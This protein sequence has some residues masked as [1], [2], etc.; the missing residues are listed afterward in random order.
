MPE[1]L[2][3]AEESA[4][5]AAIVDYN[6]HDQNGLAI[7]WRLR[8]LQP[9]CARILCTGRD[10]LPTFLDAVNQ[11][12]ISKIVR[13]PFRVPELLGH[14]EE[15]L[16]FRRQRGRAQSGDEAKQSLAER[17]ALVEVMNGGM[18]D[19]AIQPIVHTSDTQVARYYEG[20]IRPK[21]TLLDNPIALL[22]AA[23]NQGRI[24]EISA[25]ALRRVLAVLPSIP[26]EVGLFVNL[27]PEQLGDPASLAEILAT[28]QDDA[29]RIVLEITERS[30]LHDIERWD[31]SVKLAGEMGFAIA[32]DDLGAGYSS[33]SILA[34]L[35]PQFI[36]LDMSLVRGIDKK[37]RKQR[38]VQLMAAFG[39]ATEAGVI[40]EGVESI[41]EAATLE[42]CGVELLQGYLFGRP[43]LS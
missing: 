41:E 24:S 28:V 25:L 20:L 13:K 35:R 21:H 3:A 16:E 36:K 1:G 34:D 15:A 19:M 32:V 17:R 4:F 23:E 2:Q 27:H 37:P 29:H 30:R 43:Q 7:L 6:L 33:L 39:E 18:L 10:D 14:L 40:A 26:A 38:L 8:K 9:D 31:D 5:D 12:E 42:D 22:T 11:G